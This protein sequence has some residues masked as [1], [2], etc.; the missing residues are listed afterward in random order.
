MDGGEA[1]PADEG[2][3][4]RGGGADSAAIREGEIMSRQNFPGVD[5]A[6]AHHRASVLPAPCLCGV[7]G[8]GAAAK[9]PGSRSCY[10]VRPWPCR[11]RRRWP[12]GDVCM[13]H[14]A[15]LL[16]PHQGERA[17]AADRDD[18]TGA[19][20]WTRSGPAEVSAL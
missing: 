17:A 15:C 14:F 6:S 5:D 3:G 16:S 4:R 7:E 12:P 8:E 18:A 19:Y 9:T 10:G 2:P 11:R 13:S 1:P 20:L